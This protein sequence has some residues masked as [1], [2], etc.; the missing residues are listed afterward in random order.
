MLGVAKLRMIREALTE[1]FN[2]ADVKYLQL[3]K[4]PH[5]FAESLAWELVSAGFCTSEESRK[6]VLP[7]LMENQELLDFYR[8]QR[9][10]GKPVQEVSLFSSI[11]RNV[12]EQI[13]I[14][15][16]RL[17]LT[18]AQLAEAAGT[19]QPVVSRLER[20]DSLKQPTLELIDRLARVLGLRM[21]LELVPEEKSPKSRKSKPRGVT[22]AARAAG[23]PRARPGL[24]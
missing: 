12:G 17:G 24:N 6:L 7:Y 19:Q 11:P 20:G 2:R 18:Q 4:D 10:Q 21:R 16:K 8:R 5:G 13:R 23:G 9:I 14:V 3:Q 15:R 22:A 1:L